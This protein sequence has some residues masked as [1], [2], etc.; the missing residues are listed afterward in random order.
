MAA[1]KHKPEQNIWAQHSTEEIETLLFTEAGLSLTH[2]ERRELKREH[3]ERVDDARQ[4]YKVPP[5]SVRMPVRL[6]EPVPT[7]AL[8]RRFGWTRF[9]FRNIAFSQP[10]WLPM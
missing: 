1:P 8:L 6:L 7:M 9:P 4:V 2:E 5:H 3:H 10:C